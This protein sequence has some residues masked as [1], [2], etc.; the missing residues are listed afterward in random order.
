MNHYFEMSSLVYFVFPLTEVKPAN[1]TT[2]K[3]HVHEILYLSH[4]AE[5]TFNTRDQAF[6][7]LINN[8]MIYITNAPE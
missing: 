1:L 3:E 8:E 5:H 7:L 6:D 4:K 2:R